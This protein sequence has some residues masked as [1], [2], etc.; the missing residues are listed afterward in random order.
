MVAVLFNSC[1]KDYFQDTGKH[2]PTYDGTIMDYIKS[3]KDVFNSLDTIIHLAGLETKLTQPDITFFAPGDP[4]IRKT[5]YALN[6]HLFLNGRDTVSSLTEIDG[7]IWKEYLSKYIFDGTFGL[8]DIPQIDTLNLDAFA[9]QSYV[10]IS[11]VNMNIGVN[12]NNVEATNSQDQ[13]QIVR[14]AGYRQLFL[15]LI[16]NSSSITVSGALINAPVATSNIRMQNGYIHALEYRRHNFG[17][18]SF[19]F[20]Q[21]AINSL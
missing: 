13:T 11:G 20:I 14:Y 7:N 16:R 15:S 21:S 9:G 2:M 4:S 3:R 17:F 1:H 5:I 6:R 18:D 12:Y 8:L 10:S 19:A